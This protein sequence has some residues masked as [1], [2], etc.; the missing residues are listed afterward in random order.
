MPT[1]I[2]YLE[3]TASNHFDF[4]VKLGTKLR[5]NIQKRIASNKILYK[6]YFEKNFITLKLEATR[7][8]PIIEE[9]HPDILDEAKGLAKGAEVPFSEILVSL[10][11]EE[12]L[13]YNISRCTSVAFETKDGPL[14]GHNEDWLPAYRNNGLYLVKGDID[15]ER[16]LALSYMATIPGGSCGMN[17]KGLAYSGNSISSKRFRIGL[18]RS[19]QLRSMLQAGSRQKVTAIGDERY[20]ITGNELFAWANGLLYDVEDLFLH[21]ERFISHQYLA[22]TNHPI[23]QDDQTEVNTH[24]ESVKRL[25]KVEEMLIANPVRTIET[26]K[27]ILTEHSTGICGHPVKDDPYNGVTIGSILANPKKQWLE[28]CYATPCDHEYIRYS[29]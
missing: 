29:L 14:L 7:F 28:I 10:C 2:P 22:H 9:L 6:K 26:M 18:P 19:I 3:I 25:E 16:F 20:S 24:R 5:T 27:E 21:Q 23:N 17:D 1:T 13:E 4:G 8:L 15:G 11:E 12:L